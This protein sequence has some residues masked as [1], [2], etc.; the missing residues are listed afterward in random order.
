MNNKINNYSSV[1]NTD[2]YGKEDSKIIAGIA[3]LL[4]FV[5]HIFGFQHILRPDVS[6]TGIQ[7]TDEYSLEYIL[8]RFGKICVAL[9]AF[10]TGYAMYKNRQSFADF[11][12]R[13]VRIVKFLIAYWICYLLFIVYAILVNEQLPSIP[14]VILNM[15]GINCSPSNPFVTVSF[16]WYVSFYIICI[17]ISPLIIKILSSNRLIYDLL[18]LLSIRIIL[19]LLQ[20]I[21]ITWIYGLQ[22]DLWPI[23]I[24]ASAYLTAKYNLFIRLC[25]IIDW[26]WYLLISCLVVIVFI[27]A[28]LRIFDYAGAFLDYIQ[29]LLIIAIILN[30]RRK[31]KIPKTLNAIIKFL[32]TYS[33]LL[34]FMH[35][36]F[37]TA[38]KP[39]QHILYY[40]ETPIIIYITAFLIT[41]PVC[42]CINPVI[43]KCQNAAVSALSADRR[44]IGG[45]V[46][47][48]T[49]I[50]CIIENAS[51]VYN[52]LYAKTQS[53][54]N[55]LKCC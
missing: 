37:F 30:L 25:R 35:G 18:A 38:S 10:N 20:R 14:D 44:I 19:S 21:N 50:R 24:V 45:G 53:Y 13:L 31:Y 43:I 11:N 15:F 34:W 33:M 42:L 51:P 52:V 46:I 3:I 48:K 29:A 41:V 54:S 22:N 32:G 49:I 8:A 4:M 12:N 1:L 2:I 5:H 55:N 6:W 17:L 47:T 16:A 36:V 28:Y 7:I 26:P 23:F 39:L 9:F 40:S 27:G